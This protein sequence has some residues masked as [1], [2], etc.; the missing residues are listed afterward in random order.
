MEKNNNL[1]YNYLA[2]LKTKILTN[3]IIVMNSLKL[4]TSVS[5]VFLLLAS[6]SSTQPLTR[7]VKASINKDFAITK[8]VSGYANFTNN[9]T[10]EEYRAEIIK[11][12][13]INLA[14]KG[15]ILSDDNP[16][17]RITIEEVTIVETSSHYVVNDTTAQNN[18]ASWDLAKVEVTVKGYV[19]SS[20]GVGKNYP[21]VETKTDEE[22]ATKN[23]SVMQHYKGENMHADKYRKKKFNEKEVQSMI[24][25]CAYKAGNK[26][27]KDITKD[28]T[29]L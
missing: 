6:C 15:I 1:K 12:I 27:A 22:K 28:V 11:D 7:E 2:K 16:E 17:Y 18:G 3:Q 14:N 9:S 23:R 13:S 4:I 8:N 5:L 21:F 25:S 26:I 29:Q 20:T 24:G 10:D 19:T